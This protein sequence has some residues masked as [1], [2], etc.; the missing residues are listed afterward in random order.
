MKHRQSLQQLIVV[1]GLLFAAV[2]GCKGDIVLDGTTSVY[3]ARRAQE[4]VFVTV[5]SSVVDSPEDSITVKGFQDRDGMPLAFSRIPNPEWNGMGEVVLYYSTDCGPDA[6]PRF[7]YVVFSSGRFHPE[8]I[9]LDDHT[10]GYSRKAIFKKAVS[11][12]SCHP[13]PHGTTDGTTYPSSGR[14]DRLRRAGVNPGENS[15]TR[16]K[17]NEWEER[18]GE[19]IDRIPSQF[20]QSTLARIL[21]STGVLIGGWFLIRGLG[22][23]SFL[24]SVW[25]FWLALVGAG[26]SAAIAHVVILSRQWSTPITLLL[27]LMHLA[28]PVVAFFKLLGWGLDNRWRF[29]P[30]HPSENARISQ[31]QAPPGWSEWDPFG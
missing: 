1:S 8:S 7:Q 6:D 12:G 11:S 28:I 25:V 18:L 13:V 20:G 14:S 21:V 24:Q 30:G 29:F 31:R 2:L 4:T 3:W 5:P 22:S 19:L 15:T 23:P 27:G 10:F 9:T 26:I 16:N 17:T